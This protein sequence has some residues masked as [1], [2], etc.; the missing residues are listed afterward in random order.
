MKATAAV[1]PG[2][3]SS[4]TNNALMTGP[5]VVVIEIPSNIRYKLPVL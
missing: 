3:A 4:T 5:P 2:A 1:T